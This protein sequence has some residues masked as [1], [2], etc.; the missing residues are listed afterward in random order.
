MSSVADPQF[1]AIVARRARRG[2]REID[3][4]HRQANQERQRSSSTRAA[5]GA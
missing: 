2:D 5:W 3:T 4:V 1:D